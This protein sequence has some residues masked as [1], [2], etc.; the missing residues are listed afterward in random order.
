MNSILILCIWVILTFIVW[1]VV[2]IF[3]LVFIISLL[4]K[5]LDKWFGNNKYKKHIFNILI[6]SLFLFMLIISQSLWTEVLIITSIILSMIIKIF[7]TKDM[8]N[9]INKKE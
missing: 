7:W 6:F 4:S 1:G 5:S 2:V 8:K 3:V 9:F